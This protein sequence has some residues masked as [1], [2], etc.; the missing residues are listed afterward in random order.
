MEESQRLGTAAHTLV[1]QGDG[2]Q[3]GEVGSLALLGAIQ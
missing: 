2:M 3:A 1:L